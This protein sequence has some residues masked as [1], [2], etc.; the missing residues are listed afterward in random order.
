MSEALF[1]DADEGGSV[2][3]VKGEVEVGKVDMRDGI[4]RDGIM[5][6]GMRGGRMDGRTDQERSRTTDL[7]GNVMTGMMIATEIVRTEIPR[8]VGSVLMVGTNGGTTKGMVTGDVVIIAMNQVAAMTIE[9]IDTGAMATMNT[10]AAMTIAEMTGAGTRDIETTGGMADTGMTDAEMTTADEVV[11]V[12]LDETTSLTEKS[13]RKTT[14]TMKEAE[15]PTKSAVNQTK[16]SRSRGPQLLV[17][18]ADHHQRRAPHLHPPVVDLLHHD[19]I[20][21]G[22]AHQSADVALQQTPALPSVVVTAPPRPPM[23]VAA[24]TRPPAPQSADAEI[25]APLCVTAIGPLPTH[26]SDAHGTAIFLPIAPLKH[27]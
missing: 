12:H 9:V 1:V 7:P 11:I 3:G 21:T 26:Q 16:T 5:R 4:M 15:N 24:I 22:P 2:D 27:S 18:V 20:V 25:P 13:Q 14:P 23:S 8:D 10:E 6:D 19:A 17:L